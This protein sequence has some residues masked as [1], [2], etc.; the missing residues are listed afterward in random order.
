MVRSLTVTL[1]DVK[2][3][4]PVFTDAGDEL[5]IEVPDTDEL[6]K[7]LGHRFADLFDGTPA[8]NTILTLNSAIR[9][10][11]KLAVEEPLLASLNDRLTHLLAW[12]ESFPEAR[13]EVV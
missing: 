6:T 9:K 1:I 4:E 5:D 10:L 7:L 13:W 11:G 8:V 12:A 3:K 2:T